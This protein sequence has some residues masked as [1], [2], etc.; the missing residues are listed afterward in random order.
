MAKKK[1]KRTM[2]V[3][4]VSQAIKREFEGMEVVDAKTDLPVVVNTAEVLSAAGNEKDPENCILAKACRKQLRSSKVLFFR[5][6]AYVQHPGPDGVSRVYRYKVKKA[7][8]AI[9]E[10]FDRRQAVEGNVLV[11]LESPRRSDSLDYL[12]EKSKSERVGKKRGASIV[13]RAAM[14][15]ARPFKKGTAKDIS[16]RSGTGMVHFPIST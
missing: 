12:R 2:A 13:G 15:G 3:L 4:G 6:V 10:A 14:G 5:S 9:I 1:R 16:V 11:R 7:A 8:R